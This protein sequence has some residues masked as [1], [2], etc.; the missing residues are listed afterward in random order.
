MRLPTGP[1]SPI[2][3]EVLCRGLNFI[4]V[5]AASRLLF[6]IERLPQ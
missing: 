5:L 4:V 1:R 2:L 6:V 3:R